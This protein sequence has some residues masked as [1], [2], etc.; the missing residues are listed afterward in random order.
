MQKLI[1]VYASDCEVCKSLEG[2]D[3]KL[4]EDAGYEFDAF[5]LESMSGKTDNLSLY[6]INYHVDEEGMVEV[7]IYLIVT[8]PTARIQASTVAKDIEDVRGLITAW[9]Q[10]QAAQQPAG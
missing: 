9:E 5:S 6:V 2:R 10:Y 3:Q 4:A 7:P 8:G 1:K